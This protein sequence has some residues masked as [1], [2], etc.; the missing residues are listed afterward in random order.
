[1][2]ALLHNFFKKI[3][4]K[5]YSEYFHKYNWAQKFSHPYWDFTTVEGEHFWGQVYVFTKYI[6]YHLSPSDLVH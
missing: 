4:I 5:L 2:S 3:V 1:M 6:C